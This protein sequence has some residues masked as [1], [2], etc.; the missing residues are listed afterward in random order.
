MYL[1]ILKLSANKFSLSDLLD[2]L[3]NSITWSQL[4]H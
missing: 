3:R 2:R 1:F 4:P